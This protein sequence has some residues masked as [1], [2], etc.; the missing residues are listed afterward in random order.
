MQYLETIGKRQ[1]CF[2]YLHPDLAHTQSRKQRTYS[3]SLEVLQ[4]L[5]VGWI[6]GS[7]VNDNFSLVVTNL[8]D[9][10]LVLLSK[11]QVIEG[12]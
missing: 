10:V 9:N 2:S 4:E 1:S 12:F 8:V 3:R 6:C 11:L 7:L 5:I